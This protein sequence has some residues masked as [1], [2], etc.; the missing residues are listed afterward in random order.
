M[1]SMSTPKIGRRRAPATRTPSFDPKELSVP[2]VAVAGSLVA[3]KLAGSS[4]RDSAWWQWALN[5][6]YV[7]PV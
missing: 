4:D 3:Y 1:S 7:H 6:T 2:V 5:R